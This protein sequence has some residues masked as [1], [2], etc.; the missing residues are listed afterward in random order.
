M[1]CG[2]A[3]VISAGQKSPPPAIADGGL[4]IE[5]SE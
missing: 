2:N 5:L 4:S 1:P 3:S